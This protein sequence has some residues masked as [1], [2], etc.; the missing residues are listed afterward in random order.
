VT[1]SR[2]LLCDDE[3]AITRPLALMMRA[4][5][6]DCLVAGTVHDALD[7]IDAEPL[8]AAIIDIGLPDGDG[9]LVCRALRD[10]STLPIVL[11]S[12]IDGR[13]GGAIAVDVGAD[14]FI[15]KPFCARDLVVRLQH[16]LAASPASRPATMTPVGAGHPDRPLGSVTGHWRAWRNRDGLDRLLIDGARPDGSAELAL[17]ARQLIRA[18]HRQTLAAEIESY[19]ACVDAGTPSPQAA[20]VS[21]EE[22][23]V[24]RRALLELA[25]QL[26]RVP[27]RPRGVAMARLLLRDPHSP[28]FEPSD[29]H[30]LWRA[31]R[32]A[33]RA[34]RVA[35]DR[36]GQ[37]A[38]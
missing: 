16:A 24:A 30:A 9:T 21:A 11:I 4:A 17:R 38:A 12:A 26:R 8:D 29:D 28:L 3:P 5:G 6:F 25:E 7:V 22:V 10:F 37:P 20:D 18:G 14:L 2:I 23:R 1:G 31:A 19:V 15:R 35:G 32:D 33:C 36:L 27:C 34:M 13:D